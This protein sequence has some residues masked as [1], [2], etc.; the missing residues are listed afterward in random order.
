MSAV[1]LGVASLAL[2]SP[3]KTA[4]ELNNMPICTQRIKVKELATRSLCE[5]IYATVVDAI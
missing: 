2:P 3:A 1:N 5:P 4:A